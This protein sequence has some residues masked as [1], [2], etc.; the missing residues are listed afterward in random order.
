MKSIQI[1]SF[2]LSFMAISLAG[3]AQKKVTETVAVSGNCGMCKSTIEKAAKN[4][5]AAEATWDTEA[6]QL[7]VSYTSGK[8]DLAR[9]QKAV[10][11]AGY[12]TRDVKAS[13]DA[14]SKLHACCKYDRTASTSA[15]STMHCQADCKMKDGKCQDMDACKAKGCCKDAADCKEKGC[16]KQA[17]AGSDA[18]ACCSEMKAEAHNSSTCTKDCCKKA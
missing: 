6:K 11:E 7:S 2:A 9:I 1:F 12:D 16:C 5:G 14:Y 18:S 8:T 15:T 4:A 10:A 13:D 3:F 17:G